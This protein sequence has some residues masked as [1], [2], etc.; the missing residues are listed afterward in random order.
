MILTKTRIEN[1]LAFLFESGCNKTLEDK[2]RLVEEALENLKSYSGVG[3]HEVTEG[4]LRE[5]MEKVFDKGFRGIPELKEEVIDEIVD[6]LPKRSRRKSSYGKSYVTGAFDWYC[7]T[8]STATTWYV[9]TDTS[10]TGTTW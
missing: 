2:E 9:S 6:G 5:M 7:G 3:D 1:S 4:W 8:S 10:T